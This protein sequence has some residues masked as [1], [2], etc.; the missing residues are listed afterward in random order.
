MGLQHICNTNMKTIGKLD[1]THGL[2]FLEEFQRCS[3][4]YGEVVIQC[5]TV[6]LYFEGMGCHSEPSTK[7]EQ[8]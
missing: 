2:F 7:C 3:V 4:I 1:L 8:M 5:N 6:I